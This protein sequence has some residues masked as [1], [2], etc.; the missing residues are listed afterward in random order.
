VSKLLQGIPKKS[1][2][3]DFLPTK[4]LKDYHTLWAPINTNM[5]NHSFSTG[6][7]PLSLKF[8]RINPILKKPGQPLDYP[9]SYRP[10]S[11]LMTISKVL[12]RLFHARIFPHISNSPNF[13]PLQ[14]AYLFCIKLTI[15]ALQLY[16]PYSMFQQRSI[17]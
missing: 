10:I 8:A 15:R 17:P 14:S 9:A 4:L 3:L 11:N 7:C 1:N 13:N 6:T 5:A 2:I 12:E 16:L